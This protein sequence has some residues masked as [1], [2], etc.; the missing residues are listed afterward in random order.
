MTVLSTKYK[1]YFIKL[2]IYGINIFITVLGK[3]GEKY[4]HYVF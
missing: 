3:M 2:I 4:K 1:S